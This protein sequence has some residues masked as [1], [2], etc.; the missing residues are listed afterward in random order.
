MCDVIATAAVTLATLAPDPQEVFRDR[1]DHL[2]PIVPDEP[3]GRARPPGVGGLTD[4]TRAVPRT[5][6]RSP[7]G[8]SS[9]AG[10][11]TADA[12][13]EIPDKLS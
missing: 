3:R 13:G 7:T 4:P 2:T 12:S 8:S 9:P 10:A 5:G 1:R 6:N 11:R